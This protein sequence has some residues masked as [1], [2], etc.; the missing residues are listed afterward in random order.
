MSEPEHGA[1]DEE[2]GGPRRQGSE[3]RQVSVI[4][5]SIVSVLNVLCLAFVVFHFVGHESGDA[6]SVAVDQSV[7]SQPIN[8]MPQRPKA[9]SGTGLDNPRPT[10]SVGVLGNIDFAPTTQS[11]IAIA[12]GVDGT[13]SLDTEPELPG[14]TVVPATKKADPIEETATIDTEYWVQLGALSNETTAKSYWSRLSK[15]HDVLLDG[16]T[17][18][19][20]G[21]D[22]VGGSLFHLRV[23]PMGAEQAE[24][25]CRNLQSE[26]AD[27]FC[28]G[29]SIDKMS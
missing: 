15:K 6:Q 23:G 1:T 28:V 17:P 25:L 26:G 10:G 24:K 19:Y 13:S 7:S 5:L 14:L 3:R 27:C 4:G 8:P 29:P 9:T 20:F 2:A 22:S 12:S 16:R 11:V 18:Q 21:P